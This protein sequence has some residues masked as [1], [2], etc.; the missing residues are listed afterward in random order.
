MLRDDSYNNY[1]IN[2]MTLKKTIFSFYLLAMFL[3]HFLQAQEAISPDLQR[4][5]E[6][7]FSLPEEPILPDFNDAYGVVFRDLNNDGFADIYVVRFRDLNRLFINQGSE[8]FFMDLTIQTGLGGNLMSYGENNLELGASAVDVDNNGWQDI[9]VIGW[10]LTTYLFQQTDNLNFGTT[11]PLAEQFI[12]IDGNA[13]VWADIDLDGHLDLFITDEH[14]E[15]HLYHNDGSGGFLDVTADY[16]LTSVEISQGAA[17]ADVDSD[18]YPDLYVCNWF[19]GDEFYRNVAGEKFERMALPIRHLQ[20]SLS[21]NSVTFGD[22]DND[23]DLDMLVCDREGASAIY[24]NLTASGD[25]QWHFENISDTSGLTN[26]FPA[27]GSVIADFDNDGWQDVFFTNLGP[28]QLYLNDG[29]GHFQVVYQEVLPKNPQ[30]RY[31]STGAA[32]ADY[33]RD[34]DLDL[35][36]A[37]KD[38]SSFIFPNP[39]NNRDF[40]RIALE[41]VI[42]NRDAIGTKLWLYENTPAEQ[43]SRLIGY[44]EISG[45]SGYL[46]VNEPVAH[47][48]VNTES[49]YNLKVRFPSGNQLFLDDL[50]A[51]Q[52]YR[53]S[54]TGGTRKAIT[55]ALQSARRFVSQEDFTLNVSLFIFWLLSLAGFIY[56]SLRRYQW[57]KNPAILLLVSPLILSYLIMLVMSGQKVWLMITIQIAATLGVILLIGGF[58]EYFHRMEMRRHGHRQLLQNFSEQL[59]FIKNNQEL[60]EQMASTIQQAMNIRFCSVMEIDDQWI[61]PRAS[62]GEKSYQMEEASLSKEQRALFLENSV[63][64]PATLRSAFPQL[65][66]KRLQLA[67]PIDRQD[68]L[69]ALLLLGEGQDGKHL[70]PEDIGILQIFANQAA[71]AIENNLYIEETKSL[72]QRL[73]E[74]EISQKYISELEDKNHTLEQLYRELQ[75][76]QTQLIQSEKLAGLGQLV[77]GIAHELN[78]PISFVYANMKELRRYTSAITELLAILNNITDSPDAQQSLREKLLALDKKYDLNFIQEDIDNLINESLVGS[79]RVKT[80][81]QNLRNF[82]R[83]DEATFKAV[84]LHEG[85][86]STLLLLNNEM[87]NRITIHKDY[88]SLPEIYCNPG[89]INQV[90]MNLLL[91]AIQAIDGKGD[92]WV[93]TRFEEEQAVIEI[94]DNGKGIP[95]DVKSKIFDPFFTTKP[96]GK[97]TGLGLSISYNIIQKHGGKISCESTE[98][99]GTRFTIRL[100]RRG[101]NIPA[102][103]TKEMK[104]N[105]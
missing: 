54:E 23:G 31:Y 92:I 85:L 80:V 103:D 34:G 45:G 29:S 60:F 43:A 22:I 64:K 77:A 63:I 71:I 81:V 2:L 72:I 76:T 86:Q 65:S 19:T 99:E 69:F 93:S 83:L 91:N 33:D 46:S 100:P 97:G 25:S 105:S 21:S 59:I 17:F 95:E 4:W 27:Y 68:R 41:G 74:T 66:R 35:F 36:V 37:N 102:E 70:R 75:E 89:N 55:R 82:S 15:N 42:S 38:T 24:E 7:M 73:T 11:I 84:D 44:R 48:G 3:G 6:K 104:A 5:S 14:Y 53:V 50:T 40:L 101:E 56:F 13:G 57:R 88:Q 67:M 20:D 47:F 8:N 61:I 78:N 9:M 52:L 58:L 96:V 28:N 16:G 62:A 12:P 1:P 26:R 94:R 51:G 87:K 10:G 39:T 30:R 49:S 98:G 90:F 18:G 32:V 79:D